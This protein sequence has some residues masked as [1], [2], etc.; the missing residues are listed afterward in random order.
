MKEANEALNL[1]LSTNQPLTT[2]ARNYLRRL[3]RRNE[4]LCLLNIIL[5]RE[6][7]KMEKILSSERSEEDGVN[8]II[9][10]KYLVTA[11]EIREAEKAIKARQNRSK[12]KTAG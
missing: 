8:V 7:A 4:Q 2:S 3:I 5:K 10:G 12:R 6:K 9:K 11:G 1:L